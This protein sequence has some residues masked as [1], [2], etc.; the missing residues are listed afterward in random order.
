MRPILLTIIALFAALYLSAQN[1]NISIHTDRD[2]YIPADT[3]WFK[4]YLLE[5]GRHLLTGSQQS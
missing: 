3:V 5:D 1:R 2:Y 4:A